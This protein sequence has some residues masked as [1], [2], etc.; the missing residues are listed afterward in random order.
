[1]ASETDSSCV[2]SGCYCCVLWY[3]GRLLL[4]NKCQSGILI[5]NNRLLRTSEPENRTEIDTLCTV[6][7]VIRLFMLTILNFPA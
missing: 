2:K 7:F 5:F 6:Y 3:L 4:N 1:M